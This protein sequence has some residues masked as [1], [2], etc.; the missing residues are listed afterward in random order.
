M[1]TELSA[2]LRRTMDLGRTPDVRLEA[3]LDLLT[4]YLSLQKARFGDRLETSVT[5]D[6]G[7]RQARVP[8][9]L[10][11]PIV[12]NAIRHGLA[13]HVAAGRLEISARRAG[14]ELA[15]DVTDD[16]PGVTDEQVREG[17]GLGNTRARL[18]ALYPG[19]STLSLTNVAGGG[20][21]VSV[22]LPYRTDPDP[23]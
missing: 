19:A 16:G 3:E 22:R 15:I 13:R 20:A 6:D 17:I 7:V 18:D 12:E 10:L 2:L 4:L 5:V 23:A 21:R 1:I 9:L 14:N 11:Q 8:L